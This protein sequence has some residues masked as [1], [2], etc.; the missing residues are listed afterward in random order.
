MQQKEEEEDWRIS[1]IKSLGCE[2]WYTTPN[3]DEV[4]KSQ[5]RIIVWN[6]ELGMRMML[7]IINMSEKIQREIIENTLLDQQKKIDSV[8]TEN[9]IKEKTLFE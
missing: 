5:H 6:P 9:R 4:W 3:G 1:W 2:L 8:K 7:S